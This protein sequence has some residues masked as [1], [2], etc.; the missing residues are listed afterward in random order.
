[1]R[2]DACMSSLTAQQPIFLRR[3]D[4][5]RNMARFYTV[6]L[7]E[8]L[9]GTATLVRQWGRIGTSGQIKIARFETS[10]LAEKAFHKTICEK[11]RR[12]YRLHPPALPPMHIHM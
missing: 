11:Q 7:C 3:V 2:D 5:K 10:D 12:G 9:F 8:D 6:S 1:M 4:P